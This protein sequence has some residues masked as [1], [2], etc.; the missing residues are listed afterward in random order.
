MDVPELPSGSVNPIQLL[1]QA[2]RALPGGK[3]ASEDRPGI[4]PIV[5]VMVLLTV[6]SLA[7]AIM[8]MTTCFVRVIVV[9]GLLKQAMGTQ[10]I[11]PPQVTTGLALF[12]TMLVMAP[13]VER[14]N[15]EAIV[16]YQQGQIRDYDELWDRAKQPMR[17]FM[18][19]QIDATGNWSSVYMVLDYR[20]VDTSEPEK[21]TRADVDMVTLV[22]AF[23]LSELKTA[24]IMGFRI[25]L[26]FLVIDMVISTIL[27]SMSMMMLPPVMI[28][29][30]FKLLLFVM[31]DGWQLIVGSL[32]RSFEQPAAVHAAAS[33]GRQL[34]SIHSTLQSFMPWLA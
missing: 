31:V 1:D 17:D 19:A 11:P 25:Y 8:L 16:P 30:P 33:L 13:T 3:G 6:V 10:T 15:R 27:I 4:S 28:S 32:M 9:L 12:M 7:P 20:G 29:L 14:I 24:F 5:S 22:P 2:S 26:P 21:L 23:L 18:F 34:P